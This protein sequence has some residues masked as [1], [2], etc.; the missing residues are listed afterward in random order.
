MNHWMQPLLILLSLLTPT[1]VLAQAHDAPPSQP[2][3]RTTG[4]PSR[5]DWT[6]NLDATWGTFG[7]ANSLFENPKEGVAEDLSDQWFE[8]SLKPAL[9][10]VF[11]SGSSGEIYGRMSGVGE[12]TYG[13]APAL[14][15][16]DVSSFQVE[17]LTIG[18]RSAQMAVPGEH[19]FDVSVGRTPYTIGHGLL[20][21]DG[22]AEGG[23]RGGYWTNARKA[24]QFAAIG[25][26]HVGRHKADVFY[27]D[28][29]DLPEQDTGTRLWGTNYE[30]TIDDHTTLGAAYLGLFADPERAPQR[31]GLHVLNLRAYSAPLARARDLSFEFEY[32]VERRGDLRHSDGW[33]LQSAYAFSGVGWTPTLTYRYASFQGDD[34]ATPR[35]E[36]FDPLLPGFSDWGRWWQGEIVGE[37]AVSNSNLNSQLVRVHV[38]PGDAVGGGLMFYKF[39]VGQPATFAPGVTDSNL[40]LEVDGYVDWKINQHFTASLVAAGANPQTAAQQAFDRRKNFAYGMLFLAYSY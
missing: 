29:D 30:L 5:I 35:N 38:A 27:L 19:A 40:A 32:V 14:V 25:R 20:L 3:E 17:D 7:F 6:F 28:K 9:S 21:W 1:C 37:Y 31:D 23:S 13:S 8:G 2:D 18:W 22:A 12:R 10:G 4:L 11:T 15:G 16:E 39:T 36:A 24:F 33:T 26:A 34:P